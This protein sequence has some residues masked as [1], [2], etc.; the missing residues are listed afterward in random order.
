MRTTGTIFALVATVGIL[1]A[2]T[3][4][5]PTEEGAL[6]G[7][8][9]GAAAGGAVTGRSS[10]AVVGGALGALTGAVLAEDEAYDRGY[11]GNRYGYR[12]HRHYENRGWGPPPPRRPYWGY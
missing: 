8:A 12:G 1:F 4:C 6:I 9:I 11:Y 5:T 7:G 3:S 2:S 10:G